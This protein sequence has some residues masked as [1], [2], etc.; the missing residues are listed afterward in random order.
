MTLTPMTTAVLTRRLGY[1][2]VGCLLFLAGFATPLLAAGPAENVVLITIDG[3]R[4]QEVF[5][6][7]DES[8]LQEPWTKDVEDVRR[9]LWRDS[10]EDRRKALLPFFWSAIASHGLILGEPSRSPV[11]VS[12]RRNF[13][14]PG[15]NELLAGFPDD[16]IISNDPIPNPNVTVLE[17]LSRRPGFAGKVAVFGSWDTF[18]AIVNAERAG[19]YANAGWQ[20]LELVPSTPAQEML[21]R[22]AVATPHEWEN[23]RYDA[24]T[25][26]AALEYL[27]REHPRV[28]YLAPGEPDDWAHEGNYS[29]YLRS[30]R[31]ADALIAELW[32]RLESMPRYRGRTALVITTDHGRGDGATWTDHGA[33]VAGSDSVWVA[34]LGPGVDPAAPAPQNATLKQIAATVAALLG[35]DYRK[36]VPRAAPALPVIRVN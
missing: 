30:I 35:E 3:V 2:A 21:N 13:S 32:A 19:F 8:L 33:E 34:V 20:P 24:F 1:A 11:K 36:S 25:F 27:E 17:W 16:G 4:W 7:A 10:A 12:N 15:Y 14:Y 28:L 9:E 18:S 22:L 29:R 5:S 23:V 26:Y 31:R 6:G